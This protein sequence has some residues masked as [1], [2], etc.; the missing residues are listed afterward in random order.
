MNTPRTSPAALRRSHRG[1]GGILLR[2]LGVA[3]L[4][5]LARGATPVAGQARIELRAS[6]VMGVAPMHVVLTGM[7]EDVSEA[8]DLYCP[9][10][11]WDW[12]DGSLSR[13]SA[14]CEPYDPDR[15]RVR[16]FYRKEHLYNFE[17]EF[18]VALRLLQ[19]D[20]VV[21]SGRTVVM[22]LP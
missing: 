7:V 20:E 5:L 17:G 2:T 6:R 16:R 9:T 4:L 8:A 21:A 13:S 14:D 15:T 11:E 19:G 18:Q 3:V 1:P 22:V 10:V 12:G